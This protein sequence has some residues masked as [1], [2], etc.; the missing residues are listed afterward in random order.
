[1]AKGKRWIV[2]LADGAAL[3]AVRRRL[4]DA[5]FDVDQVLDEIGVVTGRGDDDV[6]AK[7]REIEA[8]EDV[9][10]EGEV[11]IAPPDSDLW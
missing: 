6:A 1:M 5:G 10:P 4:A 8:V 11:G 3:P 7:L 2:T 9:S